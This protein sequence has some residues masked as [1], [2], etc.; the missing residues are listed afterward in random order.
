M[1]RLLAL[2]RAAA[3]AMDEAKVCVPISCS[4]R[5]WPHT[6]SASCPCLPLTCAPAPNIRGDVGEH[7]AV[8][9]RL[10]T[11]RLAFC[12]Q[13]EPELREP[14]LKGAKGDRKRQRRF[15]TALGVPGAVQ[16]RGAVGISRGLFCRAAAGHRMA[17]AQATGSAM[18]AG[19]AQFWPPSSFCTSLQVC[20]VR[21]QWRAIA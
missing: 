21:P 9:R 5:F 8:H 16:P 11:H 6:R 4:P 15:S 12:T 7:S 1:S 3:L 19:A 13:V 10:L 18:P 14:V 20:C 2:T 17:R